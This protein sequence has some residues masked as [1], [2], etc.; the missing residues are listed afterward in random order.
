[1]SRKEE[2]LVYQYYVNRVPQANGDHEVHRQ[3]C[4]FLPS[5]RQDLGMHSGC[6]S[7]VQEA[8]RYY[9]QSNGCYWCSGECHTS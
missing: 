7:A 2:P 8:K 1:M 3:S 6:R 5:N 9:S 4:T